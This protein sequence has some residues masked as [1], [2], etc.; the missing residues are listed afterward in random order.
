M[1]RLLFINFHTTRLVFV[2]IIEK[3]QIHEQFY[4]VVPFKLF[5]EWR[6]MQNYI[7]MTT[8]DW[9]THKQTHK[10]LN[11]KLKHRNR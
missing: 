1:K 8:L 10:H 4:C 9:V 2:I 5:F 6:A 7:L 11:L 3:Y